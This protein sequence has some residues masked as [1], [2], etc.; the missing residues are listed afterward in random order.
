MMGC[1][2][3]HDRDIKVKRKGP[4]TEKE[5]IK[6]GGRK[7]KVVGGSGDSFAYQ[8][9]KSRRYKHKRSTVR[10]EQR[11]TRDSRRQRDQGKRQLVA[12]DRQANAAASKWIDK[13]KE[14]EQRK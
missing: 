3:W 1:S 14:R 2:E 13:I 7:R 10:S 11:T 8:R 12:D 6:L 9:G 4:E 5:I